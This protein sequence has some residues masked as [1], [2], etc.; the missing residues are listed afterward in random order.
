MSAVKELLPPSLS[1]RLQ[2]LVR[3]LGVKATP[4]AS[5]HR[6]LLLTSDAV[7]DSS[8]GGGGMTSAFE[9]S[10]AGL[11]AAEV[12]GLQLEAATL[13]AGPL[14]TGALLQVTPQVRSGWE[15]EGTKGRGNSE[16]A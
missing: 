1:L 9:T 14:P 6:F 3:L 7:A 8:G 12:P 13:L 5:R 11:Q 15:D 10:E 16:T 2:A 4:A